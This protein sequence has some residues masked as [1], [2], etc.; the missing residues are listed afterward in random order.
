MISVG[1]LLGLSVPFRD[2]QL[3]RSRYEGIAGQFFRFRP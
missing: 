2:V 3:S 1:E